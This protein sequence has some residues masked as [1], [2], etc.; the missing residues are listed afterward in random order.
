MKKILGQITSI[1]LIIIIVYI[2]LTKFLNF[3]WFN[4]TEW[5]SLS[6]WYFRLSRIELVK[7]KVYID[8]YDHGFA[9]DSYNIGIDKLTKEWRLWLW[10]TQTLLYEDQWKIG[11]GNDSFGMLSW[12]QN[13]E[14]TYH[15][16]AYDYISWQKT[17][18][19][20]IVF[21]VESVD[22]VQWYFYYIYDRK[23]SFYPIDT[24]AQPIPSTRNE[25]YKN[26]CISKW[27]VWQGMICG[28][29]SVNYD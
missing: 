15:E 26:F 4:Q 19:W 13:N 24:P 6:E 1:L 28:K 10:S 25:Y 16:K 27:R 29:D 21:Q 11:L 22:K 23:W 17:W 3:H 7:N 12:T 2:G 8:I 9:N 5:H 14:D 20:D 18:S